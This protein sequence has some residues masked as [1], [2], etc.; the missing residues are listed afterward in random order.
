MS[1]YHKKYYQD[2]KEKIKEQV[3]AI[4]TNPEN[5]D[6]MR[7]YQL[8][9]LLNSGKKTKIRQTTL[10]KYGLIRDDNDK[11]TS[12]KFHIAKIIDV[13]KQCFLLRKNMK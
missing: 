1:E 6:R 4:A 3:K 12:T 10:D 9:S 5:K 13:T 11:W 2:N 7:A 8:I